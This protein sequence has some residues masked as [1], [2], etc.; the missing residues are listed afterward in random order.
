MGQVRLYKVAN[1]GADELPRGVQALDPYRDFAAA[2]AAFTDPLVVI[3]GTPGGLYAL[4]KA[5]S[6]AGMDWTN[7]PFD[8]VVIDEASQMSL[9]EAVLAG[10]FLKPDGALLVVGDHRQMPPIVAH[11]WERD[12]RR[13]TSAYR[14]DR[15]VFETLRDQ[16]CPS[17]GL[18]ESFRLH[19]VHAAFLAEHIYRRDG[20]AFHSRRKEVL[21]PL[22]GK[23]DEYVAAA[24][25]PEYP[26]VVIE[27]DEADIGPIQPPGDDPGGPAGGGLPARPWP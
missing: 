15:S 16:G 18:D 23:P 19:Q 22:S 27:H 4:V 11:R 26:V 13:T 3:G 25:R 8:L 17:V 12:R 14:P 21:A 24:L 9:P 6:R 10:A 7:K 1:T 20:I 2:S 5:R